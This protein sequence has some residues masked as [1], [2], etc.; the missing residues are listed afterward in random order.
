MKLNENFNQSE[1]IEWIGSFLPDFSRDIRKVDVSKSFQGI[2]SIQTIGESSLGV[3][4]YIIETEQDPSTRK[5]GL[6]TESFT[7]LRDYG[8]PNAIVVYYSENSSLWRLSLLTSTLTWDEGKIKKK[9]SNPKRQ[10]YVLGS[11]AKVKTPHQYLISKGAVADFADLKSRFSLEVVNKEFYKEISSAFIHLVGGQI[12]NGKSK[13]TVDAQLKLPFVKDHS[14]TSQ[15]FAVRLIGRIIFC[16]FLREKRSASGHSLMPRELLSYE[17]SNTIEDYYH[18]ILEPI[19]FEVLNKPIKTRKDSFVNDLFS[20]IPYLNGGLFSPHEDDFFN[21]NEGKQ[22]VNH[23]MVV[24][25]DL[26]LKS[27][28][29]VLETFNFTIDENTSFD[30]EL[31]IDPEMLGRI[32]ENLLAE[33]NPETGE[34]ARKSTGSY[35]TPRVIVDYMVDESLYLFLKDKTRISEDKLRSLISYDLEDDNSSPLNEEEKDK[36]AQALSSIKILDPACGSGAFPIGALQKIVFIL[37]QIDQH[38]QLWFKKQIQNTPIE[39]RKV[40]EREF[41]EK[42]FD[43]IRKL[44]IIRENIYGIDIQPI[45]TEISR[46]RCFLTLVVDERIDDTLEN[47]GIEPLPNLDFKFVTANTLIG[48]P[49]T[50]GT[51]SQVGLFEDNEGINELKEVRDM[52][53]NASGFERDQLKLQFYQIQKGMLQRL[54]DESRRGHADLTSKL[55]TWDPFS[56]KMASWFDPEWMFGIKEGFDVVIANPPYISHVNYKYEDKPILR[57]LYKTYS[58]RADVYVVFYEKALKLARKHGTVAYI[59]PNKFF[60]AGYGAKLRELFFREIQVVSVVDFGDTP[61]FDAT[62]YPAVLILKNDSP[63]DYKFKYI[64]SSEI[65]KFASKDLGQLFDKQYLSSNIWSFS[66][67]EMSKIWKNINNNSVLL[68][69]YINDQFFRGIVTGLNEAFLIDDNQTQIILNEN[70]EASEIIKPYLRGKDSKRWVS[71]AKVNLIFTFHG[72]DITR[73]PAVEKYLRQFKVKLEKRATSANHKWYELQQPQTGIYKHYEEIKIISTDIAKQCEF[74]LDSSGS[75][76]DAT[77][78]CIP[79][80]DLYLLGVLNSKLIELYYKSISSTIRGDFLRFKKIYLDM[81]PIKIASM[82]QKKQVEDIVTE[83]FKLTKSSD[84]LEN[85]DKQMEVNRYETQIDSLVYSI[86]GLSDNEI[87]ILESVTND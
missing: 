58:G 9:L 76:I 34:S 43:Y 20:A 72:V 29:E 16:W 10:S 64:K 38:G 69:Q 52:F 24:V 60:R 55:T 2:K 21:Y 59:T 6:A 12:A 70:P 33:I 39:L 87:R 62:T 4:V 23:N 11:K 53:F 78:F 74:T 50:L 71:D 61:I 86:Y 41:Q 66:N 51:T 77:I 27:L 84:Y 79:R 67:D 46:L 56:H 18:K 22:A 81:L 13:K 17:A 42:N 35:Y 14:Q 47:R 80:N 3:R 85:I 63:A 32:F 7:L 45:A 19:F 8:T 25:P 30:E 82:T 5:I 83:I 57:S 40:I 48:L 1:F 36:I 26:W 68:K 28:F 49:T 31:S 37:Q 75:Y 15:E 54:I 44:G 73:Y 65:S